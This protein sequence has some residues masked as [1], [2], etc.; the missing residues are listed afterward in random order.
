MARALRAAASEVDGAH[1]RPG[2]ARSRRRLGIAFGVPVITV[3]GTNGKGSTCA[4]LESIVLPP[5]TA[6][7]CTRSRISSISRSAAASAAQT[8][9]R[10][11]CCRTSRRSKRRAATLAHLLRIHAA[12]DHA[13][14]ARDAARSRDPRG[15]PRR[16]PRCGQCLRWRLRRRHQHRRRPHRVPR[17]RRESI[18]REKAGIFRAR[19][20]G[21]RQRPGAAA[22]RARRGRAR[23]APT[24]A[25]PASTSITRGDRQQ[26]NWAGRTTR[27]SGL[28]Y[29]AL[30]GANQL[31]NASGALAAFEALRTACRSAR[32]PCA[33]ASRRS[34]CRAASR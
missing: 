28:G 29:P 23:S 15:R 27:F 32:R 22:K 19:Q 25:A 14:A 8:S 11:R 4:M 3:A 2:R 16:A 6:S 13:P 18:G 33:P 17:P 31:L 9:T 34:S 20:A 1:A 26:W 5:A 7:G 30:R 10:P 24:C 21:G 12:G